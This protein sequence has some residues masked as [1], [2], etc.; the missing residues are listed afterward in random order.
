MKAPTTLLLAAV[1]AAAGQSVSFAQDA[2]AQDTTAVSGGHSGRLEICRTTPEVATILKRHRPVENRSIPVPKFVVKSANN[3]F[4][5]TIGGSVSPVLGFDIGNNLY[6]QDDAGISFVTSAIPVPATAGHKGDFYINPINGAVDLQV[7]GL[8]NTPNEI[9]AY[10][11]AGTNGISTGIVLQ[12][13]YI[14]WRN[15]TAGMKLTL[16]Q[17]DYACQPPTID[18][19]GPSGCVSNVAYEVAYKSKS[20]GG[21]R[22]AAALDM[23]TFY[24]SNG[25][26]RGKDYPESAE[27][28][29]KQVVGDAEQYIPDIPAWV[30][31]SFSQ[32][33][34]VR[35][36]GILRN[37]AYRD[38]VDGKTRHK[39]GWGVMLSGN[40]QP[41]RQLILYYQLAYGH[42]IGNYLQDIA[43]KPI[44]FVPS[45][46]HPGRMDASPMMGANIGLSWNPTSRLQFNAMFSE[47]RIWDVADY[48]N[49][50]DESQNYKYALYG[51]V[52]CFYTFTPYL[53]WGIEYLWGRR[54][55]WNI[56]GANDSRIQTQIA[57]TF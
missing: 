31:Y 54:Q 14:S 33:N 17:D 41:A 2:T 22:F 49:A 3:N 57:F 12:R 43:G 30:E 56:G 8:A 50:L 23:P 20:Y 13:A 24:S 19:E 5:L 42:G 35:V 7:V 26:Y 4:I 44:S 6:K 45:G 9:S 27:Y 10:I 18:P 53:Q 39:A 55:T 15:F 1:F 52:N 48:C 36:S 51:A 37:F 32:W 40:L 21:F 29:G 11:K 28:D 25:Y 16:L 38:L 46:S 47:S 34:R